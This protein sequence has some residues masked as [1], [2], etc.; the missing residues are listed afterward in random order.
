MTMIDR[1]ALREAL[2]DYAHEAWSGWMGFLFGQCTQTF[3]GQPVIPRPLV[4]RWRRQMQTP[5]TQLSEAEKD[6][7]R[8]EADKM[9]AL[10]DPV[11]RQLRTLV[12][13]LERMTPKGGC[14]P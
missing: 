1:T 12:D 11:F 13:E 9:L 7:D 5:Y 14:R 2:A 4:E 6:S 3:N 10:I 8:A